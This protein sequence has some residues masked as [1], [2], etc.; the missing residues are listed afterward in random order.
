MHFLEANPLASL[1]SLQEYLH[2][3]CEIEVCVSTI[4]NWLDGQLI[5]LKTVRDV[6]TERNSSPTK[7]QRYEFAKWILESA[8]SDKCIYIDECGFNLWTKRTYG[9]SARGSRCFRTVDKQRGQN[10][11]VCMAIGQ[12]GIIH[13]QFLIGP[14]NRE[15]FVTFLEEL[16]Q[17]VAD[18]EVFFIMDNC[19]IHHNIL[20][21]DPNHQ[22]VYLPPYSP[23]LNPIESAFSVLKA[24]VKK[25]LASLTTSLPFIYS[26]RR[27][28]LENV[29]MSSFNVVTPEK[30]RSFFQH[31]A[32]FFPNCLQKQNILGD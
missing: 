22:I 5:T 2:S 24:E 9:R 1:K 4:A 18:H 14:Y 32:T 28:Q 15:K 27:N 23:F 11:S 21:N 13:K 7:N 17:L 31:S 30:C 3:D 6:T 29:I 8:A 25:K 16:S 19:R 12:T 10:L 26:E 20:L